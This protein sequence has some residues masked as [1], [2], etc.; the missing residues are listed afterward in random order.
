MTTRRAIPADVETQVLHD[1]GRRCCMCFALNRDFGEKSGQIA[2]LNRNP[3]DNRSANLAWLCLPHHD[4]YDGRTSQSKGYTQAEVTKYRDAL[5]DAV[6][7]WRLNPSG[8]IPAPSEPTAQS[9][10]HHPALNRP[11]GISDRGLELL[12]EMVEDRSASVLRF[13]AIDGIHIV[14][15]VR[16]LTTDDP[17]SQAKWTAAIQ[18]LLRLGLLEGSGNEY[19]LTED[20]YDFVDRIPSDVAT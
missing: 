20:G 19:R 18:E 14:V 6:A 4:K 3:S 13:D 2:H 8:P 11:A 10:A 7:A 9:R 5:H 17:R 16:E 15:G 1:S 12:N